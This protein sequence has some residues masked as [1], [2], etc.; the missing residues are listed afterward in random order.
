M[1]R[2]FFR[3]PIWIFGL[4]SAFNLVS[5]S[6][7]IAQNSTNDLVENLHPLTP[8]AFQFLKYTEMP[9][10]DYTGI[11]N[12]SVP[13]YTIQT[14]G[15]NLPL[16]LTYHAGGIRVNQDASW[17]G[18]GWDMQ[19]GSIVQQINDLDDF[20]TT[21]E[22][23]YPIARNLPDYFNTGNPM[24][25]PRKYTYEAYGAPCAYNCDNAVLPVNTP[26][27]AYGFAVFTDS[28]VPVNGVYAQDRNLFGNWGNLNIVDTEPDIFTANFLGHS[29]K[30]MVDWNYNTNHSGYVITVL[31]KK[32]YLVT[33]NGD[34]W[35]IQV[36]SGEE[37][38]F[39]LKSVVNTLSSSDEIMGGGSISTTYQPSSIIWMLTK[40]VTKNGQVISLNYNASPAYDSYPSFTQKKVYFTQTGDESFDTI[41]LPPS[42]VIYGLVK[43]YGGYGGYPAT[44]IYS[45]ESSITLSSITF[46][47][48][49]I[50][51]YSSGRNDVAGGQKLD[52][53]LVSNVNSQ[54]IKSY[55]LNYSY[56]DASAVGGNTYAIPGYTDPSNYAL[57]RLKLLSIEDNSGAK[58]TFVYNSNQ[59]PAKNSF[60]VDYW[61]YYNGRT[62]YT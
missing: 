44:R 1:N 39:E 6:T 52:S 50:D 31:N 61:G 51:F 24:V 59:L 20:E 56:F 41:H 43:P 16:N 19:I 46:P 11:P 37:Y 48:G 25:Y 5:V 7:S 28:W 13:L 15:L 18:L 53:L 21:D 26:I 27:N 55:K 49:R 38:D 32:G 47:N 40:I 8:T 45:K 30:F 17:V 57:Y 62:I 34:T 22:T 60:A 33:R 58:H 23:G 4:F 35:K 2:F 42:L 10:S 9:V 29:I 54:R 36:P 14:D 12:V 3:K